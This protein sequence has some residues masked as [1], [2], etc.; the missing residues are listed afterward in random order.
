[1]RAP[2]V[3]G[4]LGVDN[5]IGLANYLAGASDIDTL[6]KAPEIVP[7]HVVTAGPQPPNA[8]E[9][10][11]SGKLDT[12]IA[13]LLVRYDHVVIDSPPVMGLADAPII[14]SKTEG[15]VFV[16]EA[17]GVKARLIRLAIGRLRQGHARLLGT[18]LTKF[19][20]K[21]SRFG[22]EYGYGYGYG[23]GIEEPAKS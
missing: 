14:A 8:A 15:T 22:Y 10:L 11:R 5:E 21:R 23:Y 16:A 12:L 9:L 4:D 3:H 19:E 6:V 2:S 13:E 17:H 20:T 18:V 7:F 1:M